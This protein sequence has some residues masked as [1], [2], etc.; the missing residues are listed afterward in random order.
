MGGFE[1]GEALTFDER[2]FLGREVL[3]GLLFNDAARELA[4]DSDTH[5]Y[6]PPPTED[7]RR[8]STIHYARPFICNI[9][10]GS[11]LWTASIRRREDISPCPKPGFALVGWRLSV[12]PE[13]SIAAAGVGRQFFPRPLLRYPNFSGAPPVLHDLTS[14]RR[15]NMAQRLASQTNCGV[16]LNRVVVALGLPPDSTFPMPGETPPA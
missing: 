13:D 11:G 6:E 2:Q 16:A 3:L 10:E 4:E 7:G 14:I 15:S 12:I 5:V 1:H 8:T 9:P